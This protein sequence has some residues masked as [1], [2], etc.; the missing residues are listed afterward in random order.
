MRNPDEIPIVV[1][2]AGK[3]NHSTELSRNLVE[4]TLERTV[5]LIGDVDGEKRLAQG[6]CKACFY[7][8]GTIAGQAFTNWRCDGCQEIQKPWSTTAYPRLCKPCSESLQA[9]RRCCAD[10][11]LQIRRKLH[12]KGRTSRRR[13]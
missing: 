13:R 8:R 3:V 12:V 6:E 1:L 11:E 7:L 4:L 9:C 5:R 2:D 10:L